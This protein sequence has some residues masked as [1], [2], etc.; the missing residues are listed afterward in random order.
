MV[1]FAILPSPVALWL[2]KNNL[3][4]IIAAGF[5]EGM[6]TCADFKWSS[7]PRRCKAFFVKKTEE[8][9]EG[10]DLGM[11]TENKC[12]KFVHLHFLKSSKGS[13]N[14]ESKMIL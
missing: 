11:L 12:T 2:L 6:E 1:S 4:S 13:E 14:W 9:G 3:S 10:G 7:S 8:Q 5:G